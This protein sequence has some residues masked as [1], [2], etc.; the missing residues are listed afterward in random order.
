MLLF[1]IAYIMF[2]MVLISRKRSYKLYENSD[3]CEVVKTIKSV[4]L[5]ETYSVQDTTFL[6][7]DIYPTYENK[8]NKIVP[9]ILPIPIR[10]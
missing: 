2:L 1:A 3:N 7:V 6:Q 4:H 5:N 9:E 8:I 10:I